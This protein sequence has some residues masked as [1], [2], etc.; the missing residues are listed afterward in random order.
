MAGAATSAP[1]A[2]SGAVVPQ[3][4]LRAAVDTAV[5]VIVAKIPTLV[6]RDLLLTTPTNRLPRT[7]NR[8]QLLPQTLMPVAVAASVSRTLRRHSGLRK[9][10]CPAGGRSQRP[11]PRPGDRRSS[12]RTRRSPYSHRTRAVSCPPRGR[13]PEQPARQRQ[14]YPGHRPSW[15]RARRY[16][17]WR[18]RSE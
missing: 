14:R 9:V 7:D 13:G 2:A 3:S 18:R 11:D 10:P 17:R 4:V 16:Q 6:W 15:H 5:L 8:L 12:P 1:V